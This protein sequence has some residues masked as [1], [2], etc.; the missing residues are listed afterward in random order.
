MKLFSA[1]IEFK[2]TPEESGIYIFVSPKQRFTY[3][4]QV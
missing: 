2:T 1:E 4:G 3:I